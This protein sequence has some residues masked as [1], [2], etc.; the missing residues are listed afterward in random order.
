MHPYLVLG[1]LWYNRCTRT[2]DKE[3]CSLR[4]GVVSAT[5]LP[6]MESMGEEYTASSPHLLLVRLGLSFPFCLGPLLVTFIL[7][8]ILTLPPLFQELC[9]YL[10]M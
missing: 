5:L 6:G 2:G 7:W 10:Y 1:F 3:E 4:L 9:G 8:G